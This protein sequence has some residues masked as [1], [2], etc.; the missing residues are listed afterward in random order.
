MSGQP[1]SRVH[2]QS[3]LPDPS[4]AVDRI[5]GHRSASIGGYLKQFA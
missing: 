4:H 2:G 5:D 3:R 1:V